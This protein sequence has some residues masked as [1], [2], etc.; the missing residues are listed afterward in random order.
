MTPSLAR[1][2]LSKGS[3]LNFPLRWFSIPQCWRYERMA[4]GRRR[5]IILYINIYLLTFIY[6]YSFLFH[7]QY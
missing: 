1:M 7:I 4:K 2:I 6:N 3:K 5:F